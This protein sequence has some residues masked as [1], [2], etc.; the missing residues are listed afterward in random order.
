MDLICFPLE[1]NGHKS[2]VIKM[3][4]I[5]LC[6][7]LKKVMVIFCGCGRFLKKLELF[8]LVVL[9]PKPHFCLENVAIFLGKIINDKHSYTIISLFGCIKSELLFPKQLSTL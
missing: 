3:M 1:L 8:F 5:P 2:F 7:L 9:L 4:E 6:Q